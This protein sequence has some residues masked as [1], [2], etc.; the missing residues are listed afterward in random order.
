MLVEAIMRR[1][2]VTV[3]RDHT[4]LRVARLMKEGQTGVAI[5][6]DERRRPIGVITDRDLT[7]RILA[8]GRDHDT[9][10]DVFMTHPVHAIAED[11][12]VFDCLRAM[13]KHR[14]HRMPVIDA[15]ARLVGIVNIADSL[16]LLTTE[17]ANIA[18]VVGRRRDG[19]ASDSQLG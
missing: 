7:T 14:V 16:L 13:A 5:V 3:E 9:P 1:E 4:A 6:V 2:V 19:G 11:A 10:V 15:E 12:L 17:L 18:E 8:E